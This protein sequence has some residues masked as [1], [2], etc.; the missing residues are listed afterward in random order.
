MHKKN[1]ASTNKTSKLAQVALIVTCIWVVPSL[2][3]N[4]S[5]DYAD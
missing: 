1:K 4:S 2:N 5:T 3:L